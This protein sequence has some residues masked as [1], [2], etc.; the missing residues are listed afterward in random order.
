MTEIEVKLRWNGDAASALNFLETHGHRAS[1][2]RLLESDQLFDLPSG[3]LRRT[4]QVLRLRITGGKATVTYKGADTPGAYKSREE[5]EF[6]VS[7]PGAFEAVLARLG[8][9]RSFR[10]EKF[11]TKFAKGEGVVTLDETPIGIFMELEGPAYWIDATARGLGYAHEQYLTA[12]Y[13][14]LYAEFR[15]AHPE[16]PRDMTFA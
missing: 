3:E 10:Y 13:S 11:R 16:A 15:Q 9:Q 4:R 5:I 1:G 2:P 8:Y 12:S 14:A 7:D 6:D